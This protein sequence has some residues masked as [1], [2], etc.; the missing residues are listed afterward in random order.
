MKVNAIYCKLC[1]TYIYSRARHDYRSC[2]CG[3]AAVDGGRDY[4]KCVGI[5][6]N[7]EYLEI[8]IKA[9]NEQLYNDWNL[10]KEHYG[11]IKGE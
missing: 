5:P 3:K 1:N 11:L 8:E 6:M 2:T 4:F 7:V 9:N 10:G